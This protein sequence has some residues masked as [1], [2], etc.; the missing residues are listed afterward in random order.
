ML[1]NGASQVSLE[2]NVFRERSDGACARSRLGTRR[3]TDVY[4][5]LTY[6]RE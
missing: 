3:K 6:C 4:A 2:K 5:L 1:G